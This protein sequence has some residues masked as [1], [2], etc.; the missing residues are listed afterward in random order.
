MYIH[1]LYLGYR[2]FCFIFRPVRAGVRVMMIQGD[3]VWLVR[4]TYMPGWFMP[5][6]G[7]KRGETLEQAARREAYEE[8]GAVL[9]P[10]KLLGIYTSFKD[11]KT[12]HNILFICED[13][14]I[15]GIPDNEIA[16]ARAFPLHELPDGLWPG[17]RRRLKEREAG[18][19]NPQ[20][21]EW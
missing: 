16:E 19:A 13:F 18:L 15:T 10:L 12:D 17:H 6:G 2:V 5:G 4:Q 14:K 7:L 8:T 20:F 21:G 11:W 3:R 1:L 9:G